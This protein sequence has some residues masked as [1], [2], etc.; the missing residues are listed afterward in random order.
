[1]KYPT[2][3]LVFV[4]III[5]FYFFSLKGQGEREDEVS[6]EQVRQM[7]AEKDS[8]VLLDVRTVPEFD[9]SLG[10]IEGAILLPLAELESR[11]SELEKYK[12]LELILI[13]RSGNRSGRAT[14]ILR[15]NEFEA[16]NMQGGMLAWNAM[17]ATTKKDTTGGMDET[18]V[19]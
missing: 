9:G 1:L 17:L 18:D 6:V 14:Q 5:T 13:C 7:I 12:N 15:D 4:I 11:M 3:A 2:I 8:V 16:Y 10:H 19:E